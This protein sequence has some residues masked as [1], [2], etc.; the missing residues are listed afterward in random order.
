MLFG[1]C[2]AGL[3]S[4]AGQGQ[5][6]AYIAAG[7][8]DIVRLE[9]VTFGRLI[10][11]LLFRGTATDAIATPIAILATGAVLAALPPVLR[12]KRIDPVR[13]LRNG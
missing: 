1:V 12:A 5:P 7:T 10:D 9:G 11:T 4:A 2:A 8:G 13:V 3:P 6:P